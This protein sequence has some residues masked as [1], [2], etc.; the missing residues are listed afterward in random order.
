MLEY[1]FVEKL[2][3]GS[4]VDDEDKR[5]NFFGGARSDGMG[6]V[7][8]AIAVVAAYLAYHKNAGESTG[9]RILMTLVA[10][11]FSQI[12]LIYY[13]IRYV[14]MKEVKGGKGRKSGKR[15]KSGKGKSGKSGKG[16]KRK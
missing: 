1:F 16:R 14:L 2:C 6:L 9:V 4:S 3:G 5:E 15:G 7:A 13:V 12:Y 11:L 8:L 10:F